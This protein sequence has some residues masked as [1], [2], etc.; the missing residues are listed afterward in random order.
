MDE[1][2]KLY[3]TSKEAIKTLSNIKKLKKEIKILEDEIN[4]L[5]KKLIDPDLSL[6]EKLETELELINLEI[7]KHKI[8][9][10]PNVE[11]INFDE[12]EI[13]LKKSDNFDIYNKIEKFVNHKI[14]FI[15]FKDRLYN[16][17][18]ELFKDDQFEDRQFKDDLFKDDLLKDDQFIDDQFQG[19]KNTNIEI[20]KEQKMNNL[21]VE[22]PKKFLKY[23]TTFVITKKRIKILFFDYFLNDFQVLENKKSY[24]LNFGKN[25]KNKL[26]EDGEYKK[27]FI[28]ES[29]FKSKI[30]NSKYF[31]S[32]YINEFFDN[33][34]NMRIDVI[35][36]NYEMLSF[37]KLPKIIEDIAEENLIIKILNEDIPL[38]IIA[39]ETKRINPKEWTVDVL[40]KEIVK[41]SKQR[42]SMKEVETEL[43]T[44][45]CLFF[46]NLILRVIKI[47][48]KRKQKIQS[49]VEQAVINFFDLSKVERSLYNFMA[50]LNDL[51]YFLEKLREIR[52]NL[53]DNPEI[54]DIKNDNP[55]IV[56]IKNDNPKIVDIKN[57]NPKIVDIKNDNPKI[58]DIKNDNHEIVDIKNDNHEI[59]DI[60]NDNQK[61]QNK[62]D[63]S[64]D[65]ADM[66]INQKI[67]LDLKILSN[68]KK[69]LLSVQD[70][71]FTEI[72]NLGKPSVDD[73]SKSLENSKLTIKQKIDYFY[74]LVDFFMSEE[75]AYHFKICLF[76][77]LYNDFT[78]F[79]FQKDEIFADDINDLNELT[80]W[81][82]RICISKEQVYNFEKMESLLKIFTFSLS[83]IVDAYHENEIIFSKIE[84]VK[85]IKKIFEDNY[86]RK[87]AIDKILKGDKF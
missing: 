35:N 49:V 6:K 51:S 86:N 11:N 55:E 46:Y 2:L 30:R 71:L 41:I 75:K 19:N 21:F 10:E 43:I 42:R 26:F 38:E 85:L 53:D 5:E 25:L 72:L 77:A 87:L 37:C 63:V 79:I 56:D 48:S 74:E 59:V 27:G 44:T 76:D 7:K 50:L 54:V 39:K 18:N 16:N 58:V 9:K 84:I 47:S 66:D 69:E 31:K 8:L 3:D 78:K 20:L 24:F 12:I 15:K 83:Q 81:L 36:N 40:M 57:D 52:K 65:S 23:K 17:Q 61:S 80:I 68:M 34:G 29:D 22:I 64:K 14:K 67:F 28:G 73:F 4:N 82:M 60:K 1:I 13:L 70:K 32:D 33:S 62:I 45:E